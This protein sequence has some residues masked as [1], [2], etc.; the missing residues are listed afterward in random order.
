MT[1]PDAL[2]ARAL[3]DTG[4]L[5]RRPTSGER[6]STE[7]E[8]RFRITDNG[9]LGDVVFAN[10]STF[11]RPAVNLMGYTEPG[12]SLFEHP[13]VAGGV[14]LRIMQ[15]RQSRTN[16]TLDLTVAQKTIGFY[17]GAGEAF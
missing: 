7:A 11:T 1:F 4:H 5:Y 13:R 16:I 12:E 14:G 17:F 2:Q 10:M 6:V 15:N 3:P 8:W 9:L